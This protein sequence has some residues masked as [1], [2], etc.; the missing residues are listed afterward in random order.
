MTQKL[1]LLLVVVVVYTIQSGASQA[2]F[3][4]QQN[5]TYF[6]NVD[7]FDGEN[8]SKA[9]NVLVV[10]GKIHSIGKNVKPLAGA[11]VVGGT[12]RTLLPGMIDCHVHVFFD[13]Q[14]AQ[15]AM[16]GVTTELDM[17]SVPRVAANFRSQQSGGLADDRADMLSAGAAV[18][19]KSGHGT[20]FGFPVPTLDSADDAAAFIAARIEEGFRL[21]Q[22][23]P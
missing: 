8:S 7:L 9:T 5:A 20:Q 16:F 14:L 13:T 17:M 22:T 11:L 4:C 3:G 15:A 10:D 18:T 23:H 19:V 21:Y 2:A 1:I 6:Q 12:G